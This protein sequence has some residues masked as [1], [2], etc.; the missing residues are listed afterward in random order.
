MNYQKLYKHRHWFINLFLLGALIAFLC[1]FIFFIIPRI[2]P[3][4]EYSNTSRNGIIFR[5]ETWSG[6]ITV[7]GDIWAFPG[8]KVTIIP[9]TKVL[10]SRKDSFNLDFALWDLRSGLNINDESFGVK[11]G[12]LFQD[13]GHKIR[14]YFGKLYAFGS[15][16]QPIIITSMGDYDFS[17]YDFNGIY[18]HE[19]ILSFV[20]ISN[21]RKISVG[22]NVI[23]R[24][25]ELTN[26]G[27]C[28]ICIEYSSPTIVNN[29]F[30]KNLR[31]YIYI[32]G[33]S[34]KI[35]DNLFQS[36]QSQK[37]EGV[38]FDPKKIAMP[39]I[40]HNS[41]EMPNQVALHILSGDEEEG[42][43]V[44]FNDFAGEN[45][46]LLPC[47]S[48]MKFIQNLIRGRIEFAKASNCDGSMIMGPN[49]WLSRD[50]NAIIKEKFINK[51]LNFQIILPSVL[52]STPST[53]GRRK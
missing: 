1:L 7:T 10:I 25:S 13:E 17:P 3:E 35:N 20:K 43:V 50:R 14:L 8:A 15:K 52:T 39:I 32:L 31:N 12:E 45:K 53:I 21:Y 44:A 19:G 24:D 47:N 46:I 29:V 30:S 4:A 11:N 9:G 18:I 48:K 42:G 33:G 2:L 49:Y 26:S 36:S 22:D 6:V 37:G 40:Y 34:P 23:I 38:V 27:E 16:E 28:A 5:N 51:A 41:F